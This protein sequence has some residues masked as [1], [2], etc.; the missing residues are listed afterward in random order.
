[1]GKDEASD[2]A[3]ALAV[4][5]LLAQESPPSAFEELLHRGRRQPLPPGQLAELERATRL[6]LD[7]HSSANQRRQR[8][9]VMAALVDTVHD[10]TTPYDPDGLLKVITSRARRLIGFDM[11]YISLRKPDG[12]SYIHSSDGDT[13]ALNVGLV[14]EESRGLGEMAQDKG[15]PFWTADYL[16]DDRIPHG[17]GVD[18]VVRAEGLHAIMAVPIFQGS[19]PIGALYGADRVVRH[20]T[21][22]EISVMRSLADFASVALE[23]AHLL[24]R[25]QTE[26]AELEASGLKA[27]GTIARMAYLNDVRSRL[28]AQ[29]LD[30][31]DLR[32]VATTAAEA[33]GATLAVVDAHGRILTTTEEGA[34]FDEALTHRAALETHAARGPVALSETLW[35]TPVSAG[36]EHLGVVLLRV[37]QPPGPEAQRFFRFVAQSVALLLVVQRSTAVAAGPIR[38]EFLEGLLAGPARAPQQLATRARQL[39]LDPDGPYVVVLARPEGSEHGKAVVWA[40]SYAYRHSGLK[41]VNSCSIVLLLPGSDASAAAQ[42]VSDELSPLLG[43][44]VTV[45]AA[46]PADGLGSVSAVYQEA[47]RC[48]DA[49]IALDGAGSTASMDELGF[50]GVLLSEDHDVE[51][52]VASVIGPVLDHDAER[53]A[54]LVPTIEAYF[55]SGNSPTRAAAALH[56]H[57]N[58]VVRRLERITELLGAGW[59]KPGRSVDVQLALRLARA[60]DVLRRRRAPG[61]G[62]QAE[63][64]WK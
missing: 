4:L 41:T 28:V 45:G 52:F 63:A 25:T 47:Q 22:N 1:M 13:T 2:D 24:D 26:I 16:N 23:R 10:M 49:M 46:G 21:P 12:G 31:S 50:L 59:Q 56:V 34:S 64:S 57:P 6:A 7:I 15:A 11:A 17:K 5:E 48:L 44:P 53:S 33:L 55:T 62:G 42:A 3:P 36:M 40:S 19:N 35:A 37:A 14:V 54:G 29:V 39:G 58:T 18:E 38:D 32:D 30:G 27:R 51:G 43:R 60:R 9:A 61:S 8:E 20:F